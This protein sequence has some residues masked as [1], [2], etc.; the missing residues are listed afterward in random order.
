[1]QTVFFQ[2]PAGR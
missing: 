1:L 2:G